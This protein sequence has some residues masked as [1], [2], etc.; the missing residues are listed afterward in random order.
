M[1]PR[2]EKLDD[3]ARTAPPGF[4]L[5][6]LVLVIAVV[7]IL[8]VLTYPRV[9]FTQ[10]QM[11]SGAR[12]MRTTLQNA[13]RLAI[14]RQFDMVVSFNLAAHRIPVLED[15]NN[16]N[17]ADAD[18]RV[19][20]RSFDDSVHFAVPPAGL[21]RGVP[22]SPVAGSGVIELDGMPSVVFRRDG[23]AGTELDVYLASKRARSKDYRAVH[24]VR[25]TSGTE[26]YRYIDSECKKASL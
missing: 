19:T 1:H 4:T 22:S 17:A 9:D 26:W 5:I 12:V 6:E 2:T 23:A 25:A 21:D 11:D 8:A 15:R 14:T 18:E 10:F 20:W 7:G 3:R 16:N 13:Q 24:L